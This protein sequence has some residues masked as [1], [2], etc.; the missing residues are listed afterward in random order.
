MSAPASHRSNATA[1]A[2]LWVIVGLV[3]AVGA[4]MLPVNLTS[5]SPALLR[6]AGSGT[7][8]LGG[9]G[10]D[11]VDM[12][13]IGPAQL[14]L[15]AARATDDPRA[16]MLASAVQ[17]ALQDQAT[18]VPWG[19]WD[20]FLDPL[21]N[22]RS[23]SGYKGST[24]VLTFFIT[25]KARTALR[26][27]LSGSGSQGVQALLKLHPL[28]KTGRFVPAAQPGGQPLDALILLTGLLY[29]GERLS[30]PLQRELRALTD[31][32]LR[33]KQLGELEPFCINLLSLGR[34]LDW[35]QLSELLRRTDS[36]KTVG[37]YAHLARVAPNQLPLIYAAAL[38]SDS[39]DRV[40][41]YLIT[42]GKAGLDDLKAALGYGQG[43]VKQLLLHQ[44]PI[45]RTAGGS[46]GSAAELALKYPQ[47]ML[48]LK[49]IG[50]FLGVW[51]VL[52]GLDRWLVAPG[53]A[54]GMPAAMGHMKAGMLAVLF[55][56]LLVVVT[57][58]F[59]LKAAPPSEF[60]LRLPVLVA[61]S[62][63]PVAPPSQPPPTMDTS[64]L[65]S[66]GFFAALQVA[67]YFICLLKIREVARQPLS[68]LVKLRLME[69]EENL[70][71]GGLYV[72]IGGTATALVLQV[73]GVIEP[74]LLA[75]YSS[76]LFGITCVAL[77][78][79]RHVRPYKQQLILEGQIGAAPVREPNEP[80]LS[81]GRSSAAL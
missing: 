63:S 8:T 3:L 59:L 19:G 48:A 49:Y 28:T 52:R 72:G 33:E 66:I 11:L 44:V 25:E 73:L 21:F 70:F 12:E 24:P 4:W 23:N 81:S 71:D 47:L 56:M 64:T 36:V 75:A 42:F 35:T 60:Q 15:A 77:V 68:P 67:M 80:S 30:A 43:A 5:V 69:N 13:K 45:N 50:Y 9:Y 76:N 2:P 32:A 78:K 20:P 46:F 61:I 57:E 7:A 22:L 39:S 16:P 1:T 26:G 53:G 10:R 18:L 31:V 41:L 17:Q 62:N 37:E 55:A 29:Q 58:P 65:L 38:F 74:N 27:Y 79:I 54:P 40:A 14:V 51:L 34:R 6:A